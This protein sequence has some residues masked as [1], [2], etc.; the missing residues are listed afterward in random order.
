MDLKTLKSLESYS[1]SENYQKYQLEIMKNVVALLSM[2]KK[3][4]VY[5]EAL[6]HLQVEASSI[7]DRR[8]ANQALINAEIESKGK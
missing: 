5:E 6:K 1:W 4:L 7:D 2:A 3:A 8:I